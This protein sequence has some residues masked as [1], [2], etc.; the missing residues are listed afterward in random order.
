MD[1]DDEPLDVAGFEADA[2]GEGDDPDEVRDEEPPEAAPPPSGELERPGKEAAAMTEKIAV[3]P[4]AAARVQRV[5]VDTRAKPASRAVVRE[6][7][8]P[9]SVGP[10]PRRMPKRSLE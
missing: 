10:A 2:T 8:M 1:P 5:R 9:T 7:A 6:S 3:T 4:A